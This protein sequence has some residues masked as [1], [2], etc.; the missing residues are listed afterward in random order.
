MGKIGYY[1]VMNPSA[2]SGRA[3]KTCEQIIE[4]FCNERVDFVYKMTNGPNEATEYTREGIKQGWD[5]IVAAGGDGTISEVISGFFPNGLHPPKA[6]LGILHIGTSPD[7]NR[8]HNIPFELNS[9]IETLLKKKTK[10]IDV[11][12]V[13]YMKSK[14]ENKVSFFGSNI[15][16]GLGPIIAAKA[17]A[18]HRKFLGDF[19][20]TLCALLGSL[21]KFKGVYLKVKVDGEEINLPC[22]L[23]LTVGKDPYLASGMKVFS[24]IKPDDGRL[25]ILS[26]QKKSL[27]SVMANIHK[28]Y[29]GNFLKY[30]GAAICYGKE[31]EIACD[32]GNMPI[33]FD[34]DTKGYLPAKIEV[35]NKSLEVIVK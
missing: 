31:V 16:V 23:N 14:S 13:T 27:L 19:L 24:D 3:K 17:N 30:D 4:K 26:V 21:A 18:R 32:L 33:E 7:F 28:L 10:L 29:S 34:G 22:L 20:G 2:R 8:Y 1:L 15:N 25:Y 9:A 35:I 11:G 12:K 6:R 5:V